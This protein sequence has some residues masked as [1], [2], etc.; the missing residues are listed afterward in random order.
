MTDLPET[1]VPG[2]HDEAKVRKMKYKKFGNTGLQVSV[3]SLGTGG[4]CAQYGDYSLEECK[5]TVL[6]ALK[7]GINYIDTAPWYGHGVSETILGK[8]LE[9][10][11]RKAYYLATKVCRYEKDPKEMFDFSAQ[12]T[13]E[14]INT[15]LKRLGVDYIDVL[16]VHDI[17]FAPSLDMVLNETLPTVEQ[18]VKDGKAKFIGVTGYPVSTLAECIKRSTVKIDSI[19]AYTRLSLV[20]QTLKQYLPFFQSKN[21]GIINAAAHCMGLLSDIGPPEWHPAT[22]KIME[23]CAEA[24]NYCKEQNV[25]IG[26]LALYFCLQQPDVHTNLVGMNRTDLVKCNLEVLYAGLSD[27]EKSAMEHIQ[28]IFG[29]LTTTHWEGIEIERYKAAISK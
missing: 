26:K 17:E 27:K 2:F 7:S 11:P 4:F 8:C 22:T 28:K 20:D 3:L 19:L 1:F 15:S 25:A 10:I 29:K 12:K 14:S 23:A 16:Q 24:R 9:G 13:K 21:L 6:E 18:A 5:A